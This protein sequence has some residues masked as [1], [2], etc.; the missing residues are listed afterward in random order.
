[1][2]DLVIGKQSIGGSRDCGAR[3]GGAPFLKIP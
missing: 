2:T 1:V 3:R